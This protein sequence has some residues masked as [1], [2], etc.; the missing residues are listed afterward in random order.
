MK[1][2]WLDR[3]TFAEVDLK[4]VGTYN[5]AQHAEDLLISYA[6]DDGPAMVWD[7]TAAPMPEDLQRAMAEAP[8]VIAHNA[9][10]DRTIHNGP[11]QA[12]LPRIELTRWRCSMAQ[13]LSHA[14][15]GGL[16]DLCAVLQVPA[17][18]SK[19]KDGKKLIQIFT[20]L[21][22]ENRKVRRATRETHPDEWA[23]FKVYAADDIVAMRECVRRMPTWNWNESAIA[24]WHC[25]QRINERGF[26]VDQ[27]LTRAGARAA[28]DEKQKIGVR[29]RELTHGEVD[30]PSQRA[31]FQAYV[32]QEFGVNLPDTTKDTFTQMLKNPALAPRL[33]ELMRLSMAANKTST[34]KYATLDPAVSADGRFRGGLQFAGASRTRRWAGRLFQPQN[35]P[36]RGLPEPEAVESY[37]QT[38]KQVGAD[39]DLYVDNPMLFGAAALRG[40]VIAPPGKKL[41]VADLSNIEG[42]MLSW[43]AGEQW[44]LQA[45]REY[46]AGRGPDLYKVTASIITGV[47]PMEVPKAIRNSIG[48]VADLASGYMG[49]VAGYQKFAAAYNVRMADYWG[50]LQEQVSP[51]L[52]AKARENLNKWGRP[53]L[54]SLEIDEIEWLASET[55]KLAWRERH[56][57]TKSFWYALQ[58]A[59]KDAIR[60]PGAVYEV[61]EYIKVKVA[62]HKG[63]RW[64]VVRLPSGRYITYFHP[65]LLD[66]GTIAY[67]GEAAEEGKTT[68]QWVKVFTHGGKM[69]GNVCQTTSR[70]ILAPALQT[71]EDRGYLP[72][73]SVH[74]EGLTEVPD[75]PEFDVEGL[76]AI[77]AKNPAWAPDIPLS[78][79]GFAT[80]RYYK[81]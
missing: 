36:S 23:R 79:E 44:K 63:Q 37:I 55:C 35:L 13:A 26:A 18:Q 57:A 12:H 77:L 33:A 16:G 6:I 54:E 17:D 22:P 27:E 64:L 65:H 70:D 59:A 15:P 67:Y 20:R 40:V 38:L 50:V 61:G 49:G 1:I 41:V 52:V 39:I 21:Q 11:K 30:R 28:V 25:D 19:N 47:P 5:Y 73:L 9:Q 60:N 51:D 29:F 45:F 80:T 69:T 34:A 31:Q 32:A 8:I 43:V 58:N 72:V 14:L 48:K 3:E 46:D 4:V 42:R 75:T 74:D 76:V 2:L 68:R 53:Q 62:N 81:G 24:E 7:C 78:A 71:A 10:F 66:D 56:P